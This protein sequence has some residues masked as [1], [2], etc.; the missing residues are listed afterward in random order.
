ML[1]CKMY[2]PTHLDTYDTYTQAHENTYVKTHR[3]AQTRHT[4]TRACTRT[5]AHT[6]AHTN[7][8]THTHT[9]TYTNTHTQTHTTHTHIHTYTHTHI[10]TYTHT[11]TYAHTHIHTHTHTNKHTHQFTHT[12]YDIFVVCTNFMTCTIIFLTQEMSAPP[13]PCRQCKRVWP[14]HEQDRVCWLRE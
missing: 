7:T 4:S 14:S 2:T 9:H 3:H 10:H 1:A 5:L 6:R 8:H 11:H 13:M 12:V